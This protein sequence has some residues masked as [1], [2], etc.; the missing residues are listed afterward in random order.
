M[1]DPRHVISRSHDDIRHP[2]RTR[3]A[4]RRGAFTEAAVYVEDPVV[5]RSY[6]CPGCATQLRAEIVPRHQAPVLR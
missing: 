3:H 6:R 2:R 4:R 5:F 1:K